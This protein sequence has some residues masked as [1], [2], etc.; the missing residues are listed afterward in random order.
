MPTLRLIIRPV[1]LKIT[2]RNRVVLI[3]HFVTG[4]QNHNRFRQ[5]RSDNREQHLCRR[6]RNNGVVS[7]IA[8]FDTVE[9]RDH[10]TLVDGFDIQR[11]IV[12]G[13]L[14]ASVHRDI[15]QHDIA[16]RSCAELEIRQY[17]RNRVHRYARQNIHL[18]V[19]VHIS[20]DIQRAF[21]HTR[22]VAYRHCCRR[23]SQHA[24]HYNCSKNL[25]HIY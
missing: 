2:I 12:Q 9:H 6:G 23:D 16:Q 15:H 18:F 20:A 19:G 8:V 10:R 1:S 14:T 7:R 11:T 4:E 3:S 13:Q 5:R 25:F 22:C 24:G 21:V 17:K